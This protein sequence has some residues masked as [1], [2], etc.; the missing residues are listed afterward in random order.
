MKMQSFSYTALIK[1]SLSSNHI[2]LSKVQLTN[3][4]YQFKRPTHTQ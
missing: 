4:Y 1:K 3:I 2:H